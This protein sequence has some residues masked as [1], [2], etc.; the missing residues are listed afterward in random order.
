MPYLTLFG[1]SFLAAT[2][3]PV[4]SEPALIIFVRQGLPI[5]PLVLVATAGNYLGA[6]TTY[7]LARGAARAFRGDPPAAATPSRAMDLL[8]RY[9][10]PALLLSWLPVIG[11]AI[12]AAAGVTR[13]PLAGFTAW[14][15]AG[16]LARY[17]VVA[18]GAT[19]W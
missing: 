8:T 9:G 12:V 16:K 4:G 3:I 1:W 13:V 2:I 14:T 19:A 5:V 7:G 10:R 11:D 6:C 15:I 18:W 17:A